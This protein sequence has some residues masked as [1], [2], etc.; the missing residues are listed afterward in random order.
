M[1]KIGSL[2]LRRKDNRKA[3][4][5]RRFLM[6]HLDIAINGYDV[7]GESM[8]GRRWKCSGR[9]ANMWLCSSALTMVVTCFLRRPRALWGESVLRKYCARS[10][11]GM[12]GGHAVEAICGRM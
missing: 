2:S 10:V 9:C 8:L 11:L 5:V 12:V 6:G 7:V 3:S 4:G 1:G